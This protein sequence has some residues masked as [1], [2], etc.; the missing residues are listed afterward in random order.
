MLNT[1]LVHAISALKNG[2]VV[3]YPTDTLYALGADIFND[4]AVRKIFH[5]KQRP[6]TQALPVAVSNIS[7]I[8]KIG[9][10]NETALIL[11]QCFLPGPLTLLVQKNDVVS[12]LVTGGRA[13]V[14]VRIPD[15][16]IALRL[17]SEFGPLTVTSANIHAEETPGVIK[18]IKMQLRD[19]VS[20]FLSGGK[21]KASPSTIVDVTSEKPRIVRQGSI[22]LEDIIAVMN[23]G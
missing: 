15:N 9:Y 19:S 2:E 17:L 7:D 13:T 21:L 12:K 20:V 10:L 1:K 23:N 16:A 8:E 6:E 4:I 5:I 11:A 18:D 3:V 22:T 14:A